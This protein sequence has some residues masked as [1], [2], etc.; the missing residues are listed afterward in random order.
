MDGRSNQRGVFVWNNYKSWRGVV[1]RLL[2][3]LIDKSVFAELKRHRPEYIVSDDLSWLDEV[4]TQI[5][6]NFEPEICATLLERLPTRYSFI[7]AFHGCRTDSN[8]S[9]LKHGVLRSDPSALNGTAFEIFSNRERVETAIRDL[10][11]KDIRTSYED[12]NRGKVFFCLQKEHLIEDCGHY[13]LYGSEYLLCIANRVGEP[14]VL[15]KRGRA[16]VIECNVPIGDIPQVYLGCLAGQILREI[17]EK[18]CDR[19]YRSGILIFGFPIATHLAPENIV[20]FHNPTSIPNPHN[21][22]LCEN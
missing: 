8:H 12:H 2:A 10:A 3:D 22:R 18:Y 6:G 19:T 4:I 9:Y 21:Y 20:A 14:E 15:R 5:K 7:R 1:L 16:T 17:F 11:E 13:L